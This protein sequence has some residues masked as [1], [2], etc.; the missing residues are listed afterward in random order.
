MHFM[1]SHINEEKRNKPFGFNRAKHTRGD[2]HCM[3]IEIKAS[4]CELQHTKNPLISQQI[5]FFMKILSFIRTQLFYIRCLRLFDG[6]FV[7][8]KPELNF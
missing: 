8:Q 6:I 3:L 2:V 5:N 4:L 1:L 7:K